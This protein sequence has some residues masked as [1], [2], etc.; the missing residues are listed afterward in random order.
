MNRKA[1]GKGI[2]ALIPDF[3]IGVPESNENGPA[4]NTELLID[5]ISPNRFQPR[6]YFDND[7]L[8]ELVTSIREYGVLQPV[9]VQKAESG[10]E[11]VVGERRWRASKKVG[12]KK[13]PAVIRE[14]SDAQALELAIIE[15]IHRQD[16]NPIEEAE[17]Y[18]R[19]S[20][21]FALTQEMIAKKVGKSRTAVA[22]TLRLLK[23]SRNIKEDLISGKLSMG[24]ARALLGLDNTGQIETLRKEI[25]KQDLTVRQTE[26]RVNSLK[27]PVST[28]PVSLV[29]KK[30][31]F[32]KDLEKQLESRLGTKVDINPQKK[33]G[34][35][36]VTYY[37]DDD[38]DRIQNLI[39]Q[40]K[41]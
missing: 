34:K 32:I 19:L 5:E 22:N 16:L 39:G 7:K 26:S 10:Y 9:V 18:S 2:N 4:K 21:E 24:H 14:V 27:Q 38:L 3:E 35:L 31:I 1:L 6:K 30:N 33:G 28:K 8:E 25:F 11:L 36:V 29:S 23:L 13:I 20:D 15:N 40:N 37:T 41:S 12:L 17:A